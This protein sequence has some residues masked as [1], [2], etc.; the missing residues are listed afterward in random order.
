MP[1]NKETKANPKDI[2]V[3]KQLLKKQ[4]MDLNKLSYQEDIWKLK[5]I[6][7]KGN[8]RYIESKNIKI[9]CKLNNKEIIHAN[10]KINLGIGFDDTF[11]DDNHILFIVSRKME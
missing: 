4:Q 5:F 9:E 10:E 2:L 8:V 7:E 3:N 1:L 11:K 6:I